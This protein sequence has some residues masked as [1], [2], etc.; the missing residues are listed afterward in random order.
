MGFYF[1]MGNIVNV[2][3]TIKFIFPNRKIKVGD[4]IEVYNNNKKIN[5]N[6]DIISIENA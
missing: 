3:D 4:S 6:M 5:S 2:N 1:V